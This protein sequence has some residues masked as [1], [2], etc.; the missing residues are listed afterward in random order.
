MFHGARS[1]RAKVPDSPSRL[2]SRW[3][4]TLHLCVWAAAFLRTA[5]HQIHTCAQSNLHIILCSLQWRMHTCTRQPFLGTRVFSGLT[6]LCRPPEITAAPYSPL[7]SC[8]PDVLYM[9][10]FFQSRNNERSHSTVVCNVSLTPLIQNGLHCFFVVV[11]DISTTE[12]R[13]VVL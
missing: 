5:L 10:F 11:Q 6:E 2:P 3:Y 9:F 13:R 8:H 7:P 1:R 12:S 4:K